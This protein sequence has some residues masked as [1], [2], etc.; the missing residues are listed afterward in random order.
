VVKAVGTEVKSLSPGDRVAFCFLPACGACRHCRRGHANLC[1]PGS[2]A[3]FKGTMLDG[4]YR[5]F[6]ARL[7]L[8]QFLAIGAF[9]ERTVVP[10]RS[11]VKIPAELSLPDAA[12][13]G[14]AVVTGFGAVRNKANVRAG[15]RV[16]VIGCG[17][18][19]LQVIAAAALAGA[20]VVAIDS[21]PAKEPS[22]ISHG[23]ATFRQPSS[24]E[25]TFD[26]VFEVVGG[27]ATIELAWK[28]T[29]AG[30]SVVVV[31]IAPI[32]VEARL[33]AI[34][35]AS[36]KNLLGSFYGSGNPAQEIA[37][38]AQEIVSGAIDVGRTVTH[39][40]DLWG[41]DE[42]FERMQ[43]GEGLRTLVEF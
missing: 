21:A 40:T 30:G 9:A 3:S 23:A 42:A 32:G 35:F 43:K 34:D 37:S 38:L 11:V 36:E 16:A 17:G 24:V 10:E 31:G 25:G 39:R 19:G 2:K 15:D 22:A 6:S 28:L 7:P 1:E 8:Q 26:W 13:L 27:A 33:S 20:E 5:M 18:V 29:A 12:L 4:T 41:I 14:C